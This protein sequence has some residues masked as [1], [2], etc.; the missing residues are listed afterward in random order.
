M[1]VVGASL[2]RHEAFGSWGDGRRGRAA[3][4]LVQHRVL[5]KMVDGRCKDGGWWRG[6]KEGW[7]SL[8]G[9]RRGGK[10]LAGWLAANG[11]LEL[12]S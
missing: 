8:C 6:L 4:G 2:A 1:W 10:R 11:L 5:G 3:E 9:R 7:S 12:W